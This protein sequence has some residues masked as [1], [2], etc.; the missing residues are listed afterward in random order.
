MTVS[1]SSGFGPDTNRRF[2]SNGVDYPL[3]FFNQLHFQQPKGLSEIFKWCEILDGSHGLLHRCTNM[4]SMYP[5]TQIAVTND[6]GENK[7]D[8]S[9]LLNNKL[10]L[11][12]ELVSI[13]KNYYTFGNSV[14]SI[15]PPFKRYLVCGKCGAYKQHCI[16]DDNMEEK[17]FTWSFKNFKFYGKCT[18]KECKSHAL[19][20]VKDEFLEGQDFINKLTIQKWPVRNIKIRD[21]SIAGKKRIY[22]RLEEK[23]RKPIISGDRF[24]VANIPYTF[25]LAVKQNMNAAVVELPSEL[26]FHYAY[27]SI[28]EPEQDGLSKPFFISAWKDIFMSFILRK[29]QECIA[30]DHLIPNRFIF[31][32]AAP[33]GRDPLSQIDGGSWVA[34]V[35]TQL[36]RQQNDPNEIGIVPGPLGYQALG[37]Q[38]KAMSLREEIELQDR[39]LLTQMGIPPELIYGG[40]TWSGSNISLR[41]LENMFLYYIKK[42]N[43]FL[44]FFVNYASTMSGVKAPD[45]VKLSPFK[46]ADDIQQINML[47]SLGAQGRIS[48]TTSLSQ[49]GN[50]IN[51]EHEATQTESDAAAIQRIAAARQL[52]MADAG[53]EVAK[54]TNS[55]N[56]ELQAENGLQQNQLAQS[57]QSQILNGA[58]MQ[59]TVGLV[60]LLNGQN[61]QE[62]AITLR[63]LQMSDPAKYNEIMGK[64]NGVDTNPLPEAKAPRSSPEKAKV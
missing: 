15:V 42:H 23:Y 41:M 48:E 52:A 16:S 32:T 20:E 54:K 61:S 62:R 39:R 56:I 18:N 40:M 63:K 11:Q 64:M 45:D 27:E 25:I 44:K 57:T 2:P 28:S 14:V 7:D 38:G 34:S 4:L 30:S 36:K 49:V 17:N 59:T 29:A 10:N 46:M 50:G 33:G 47:L 31:P 60:N 9:N 8:W 51:L 5:V 43:T 55:A 22:Y 26:T 58:T 53:S 37:G 12:S 35:T 3:H 24:V 6:T 19:M 13:G 1:Y 21:L